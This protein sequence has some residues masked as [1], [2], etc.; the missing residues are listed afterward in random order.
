MKFHH[1]LTYINF[2]VWLIIVS[3][4]LLIWLSDALP[5]EFVTSQ[6]CDKNGEKCEKNLDIIRIAVQLGRLDTI[7]FGL[8]FFAGAFGL[9]ALFSFLHIRDHAEREAIKAA[10][11]KVEEVVPELVQDYLRINLP[12]MVEASVKN[13]MAR[14]DNNTADE[15]AAQSG[16][17]GGKG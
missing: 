9:I 14:I 16:G 3:T 7:S 6:V 2:V 15:A 10:E 8:T 17:D 1:T 12:G 11:N 4:L 5:V 13:E